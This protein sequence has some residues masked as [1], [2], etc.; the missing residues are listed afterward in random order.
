MVAGHSSDLGVFTTDVHLPSV[1]V[2]QEADMEVV[3]L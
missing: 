3:E 2:R 1:P